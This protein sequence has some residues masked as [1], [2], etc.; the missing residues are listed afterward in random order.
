MQARS[1]ELPVA[2]GGETGTW[3]VRRWTEAA[4]GTVKS[5]MAEARTAQIRGCVCWGVAN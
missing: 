5:R 4:F 3:L 1:S 2:L